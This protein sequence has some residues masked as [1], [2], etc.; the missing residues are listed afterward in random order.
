MPLMS[1]ACRIPSPHIISPLCKRDFAPPKARWARQLNSTQNLWATRFQLQ[2]QHQH[3]HMSKRS[4]S[5]D[6]QDQSTKRRVIEA[7]QILLIKPYGSMAT[8][9]GPGVQLELTEVESKLRR[10]L[11]DVAA[12]IDDAPAKEDMTGVEVPEELARQKTTL[13]WT[14]G[15][16]RDKLL[17][18]GSQDIDLAIN[19]MTGEHF[20][21]KMQ[22]YLEIPGHAEKHDLLGKDD[23][24][25]AHEKSKN[26]A[27]GL[28][29]IEANPEKSKN[30]ETATTKIMGI[31][32]DL[33]N[34]RKETY[35]EVSRNPQME[36]GTAEE[37]AM[38][39]D[40]T[41][42]AMFYNL[43]TCEV[44]DFTQQGFND[45]AAKLIRTPLEPTQTFKD[46]P[47]R[48]LRL[49]RFA[50]R[51]D[52]VIEAET[53]KAMGDPEIQDV[54]KIKISR[55]R[56]GIELEK[57]LRGPRPRMALELIDRFGLYK[58]VFT[59]PTRVLPSDPETELFKSSYNFVD[60]VFDGRPEIPASIK[61]TLFRDADE[62]YLAWICATVMPW[63]DAPTVPHTK[64]TQR[65]FF[66]AYLVAREG[67][68]A[69]NKVCDV[70]AASLG[71]GEEVRAM[72]AQCAKGL[73][74]PD[75]INPADNPT[76]RD[77]LGMALRR[78]GSTWRTQVFFNLVYEVVQGQSSKEDILGSYAAFL[79]QLA[80]HD[81]LDVDTFKP[82]LKG[83]DLAKALGTKP[84]PWM[85]D[86]LDVVMAWQLRNPDSIDADAAIEA[87]RAS[88]EKQTDSELPFR[89]ASHFLE[90]TIPPFFPQNKTNLNTLERSR[91]PAP[92]KDPGSQYVLDLLRWSIGA[93]SRKEK[94]ARWHLLVPP[95]LKMIDDMDTTWKARGCHLLG[96]LLESLQQTA[97][98]DGSRKK[99]GLGQNS[100]DFL[101]RTGY[102]NVFAEAL[103]PFFT[104]IPSLTPEP[105]AV[106][107]FNE[108]FPTLTALALLLP[109]ESGKGSTR[110]G[111][112][113]KVVREGILAPLGHFP[114]PWAHPELA[115]VITRHV[116]LVLRHLGIESV[117]HLRTLIPL[118][119]TLLQEP[120]IVSHKELTL[121]TL[122]ALQAV[123]QNAWPRI[124]GHRGAVM[125]G[126][127]LCWRRCMEEASN[128][129]HVD[130]VKAE[131]QETVAMLDTVMQAV[132][133]DST[134]VTWEEE[135]RELLRTSA[136]YQGL[137]S[138]GDM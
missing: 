65:P 9:S 40:A 88:R 6:R 84:G 80:K 16:V 126:L 24:S 96:G 81:I 103:L 29:K 114:K 11:L 14:G 78:W 70:V 79:N 105:E 86:A 25:K 74:R 22:E 20:G 57:M 33:V 39:R 102:H 82:L 97:S 13:R 89:L 72:V 2:L 41:I 98:G 27:P 127:C 134:R 46:D 83:T 62:K 110:T 116:P 119:S 59:D 113:D 38:R 90:L 104:Y 52:Y 73:R 92:W 31:D 133:D 131:M 66:A 108:L 56:V 3:Q 132:K 60:S 121:A 12:Y 100:A 67:F 61:D 50:S 76:G 91:Q 85:K 54:L 118:L 112:L 117:K 28:H 32:L 136:S 45:M 123:M 106:Q 93:M 10:L 58:T 51:L 94:E 48:V 64:P 42:N 23:Q 125:V 124:P 115:A 111:L 1:R 49:I 35:N 21:L 71:H 138:L 15:W 18:V 36:F 8:E 95:I 135:K 128:L 30:L 77:I 120:F 53:A 122:K 7:P 101:E 75:T 43:H 4:L 44:E 107:L 109:V 37:D 55:E 130:E 129:R 19:N 137:F 34:L 68:K 26:I 47:L 5:L 17:K 69:P 87:V 99:A 63:A